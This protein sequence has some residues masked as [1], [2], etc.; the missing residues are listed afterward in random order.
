M[1]GQNKIDISMSGEAG[2]VKL[3]LRRILAVLSDDYLDDG[4]TKMIISSIK[5]PEG[6]IIIS[7]QRNEHTDFSLFKDLA[8]RYGLKLSLAD[9]DY[10]FMCPAYL[11]KL[12]ENEFILQQTN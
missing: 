3:A 12:V 11:R 6:K 10:I 2:R 8:I 5:S 4:K 1:T 7:G 9:S